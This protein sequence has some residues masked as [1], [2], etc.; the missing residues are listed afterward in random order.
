MSE[1]EARIE[2]SSGG[3]VVRRAQ[4]LIHLLLIRDP[5]G[6]WGLPKGHIEDGETTEEAALR[7]VNEETGLNRI[8]LGP[9]LGTIDWHFKQKGELVHKYCDYFLMTSPEGEATPQVT[10]GITECRWFAVDEAIAIVGYDN[11]RWIVQLAG[12]VLLS[13]EGAKLL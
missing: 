13:N 11:T 4:G 2:W 5:Y 3:V 10:E 7:E 1:S 6:M 12:E 8:Q 9:R